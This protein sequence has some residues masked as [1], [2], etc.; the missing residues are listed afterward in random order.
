VRSR[1]AGLPEE[2]ASVT[3]YLVSRRN[4][5]VIDATV[6]VDGGSDFV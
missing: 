6:N 3:A 1:S 4:V 5:Y 2:V